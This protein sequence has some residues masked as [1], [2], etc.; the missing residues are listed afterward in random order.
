V[1]MRHGEKVEEGPVAEVFAN[2][3]HPYT[4]A[5]LACRPRLGSRGTRLPT[6]EDLIASL[7][8][9]PAL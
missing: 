8:T 4:R 2:P 6:V 1:L 3:R 5:L 9:E 7:R